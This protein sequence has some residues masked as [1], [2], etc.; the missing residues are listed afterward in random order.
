MEYFGSIPFIKINKKTFNMGKIPNDNLAQSNEKNR[1]TTITK[2]FYIQQTPVTAHQYWEFL[3]ETGYFFNYRLE[4][5][6]GD[7]WVM[8]PSFSDANHNNSDDYPVV[9]VSYKDALAFIE[10]SRSK[11]NLRF[12]LP[13]EA[14]FELAAK[15]DCCCIDQ[16]SMAET[17][18]HLNL[19]RKDEEKYK[20]GP[21]KISQGK[22]NSIGLSCMS[23]LIW[24]WCEDWYS[25]YS[26]N[27]NV[28][29]VGPIVRPTETRWKGRKLGPTK[30]IRGGSFSYTYN[31]SRCS[32]RHCSF[33]EDRNMNLGFRL[34]LNID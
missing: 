34:C 29:P 5:W 17:I 11:Y 14:E 12:R 16:C 25:D 21:Y 23:G 4:V 10:W 9:G 28:D 30:V 15:A 7:T 18:N 31:H 26:L 2:D 3:N 33:P 27:D 22:I 8:G 13:T 19:V 20:D 1:T 6:N 32:N 24:Q